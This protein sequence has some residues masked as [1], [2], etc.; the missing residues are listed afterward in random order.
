[1]PS[2]D[3][4]CLLC[5]RLRESGMA[6]DAFPDGV[7]ARIIRGESLHLRPSKGDRGLTFKLRDDDKA[8]EA[9]K[10]MVDAGQLPKEI[11]RDSAAEPSTSSSA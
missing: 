8:R 4:I 10:A 11:L 2:Y 1:M 9:A 5:S 7:P 6:C 3:P